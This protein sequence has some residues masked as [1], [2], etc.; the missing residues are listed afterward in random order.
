MD[1]TGGIAMDNTGGA[2]PE[3]MNDFDRINEICNENGIT[4][5]EACIWYKRECDIDNKNDKIKNVIILIS[6]TVLV[7]A[8]RMCSQS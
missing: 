5:G 1:N 7:L 2:T 3:E 6:C 4:Y 8:I